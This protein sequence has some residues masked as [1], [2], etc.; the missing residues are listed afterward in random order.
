MPT[1]LFL[2][3]I[4]V[5]LF[6]G[7]LG[8][9]LPYNSTLDTGQVELGQQVTQGIPPAVFWRSRLLIEEP[10]F[11]KFNISIQKNALIGVYGRRGLPPSH[12]QVIQYWGPQV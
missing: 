5:C 10:H 1:Y 7:R 6:A 4:V 8:V 12:T 3:T 2:K 11:L 9:V